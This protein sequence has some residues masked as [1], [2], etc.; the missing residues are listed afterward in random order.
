MYQVISGIY[1]FLFLF[2]KIRNRKLSSYKTTKI[3]IRNIQDLRSTSVHRIELIN[4]TESEDAGMFKAMGT[5]PCMPLS[6]SKRVPIEEPLATIRFD[7]LVGLVA[8]ADT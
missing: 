3:P 5:Q 2:V 4:E 6:F 7:R 1:G 8:N